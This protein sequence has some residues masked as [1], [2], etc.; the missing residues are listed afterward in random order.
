M[1]QR[2]SS[3]ADDSASKSRHIPSYLAYP[4]PARDPEE[5]PSINSES[6]LKKSSRW[7]TYARHVETFILSL[8]ETS[9]CLMSCEIKFQLVTWFK[10]FE[11]FAPEWAKLG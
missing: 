2:L 11:E 8:F 10:A 6:V 3:H 9:S 7:T 4:Y 1:S 5:D